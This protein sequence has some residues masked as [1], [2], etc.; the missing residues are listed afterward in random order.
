MRTARTTDR[1]VGMAVSIALHACLLFVPNC[2]QRP[3]TLRVAR[4]VQTPEDAATSVDNRVPAA[5]GD[6]EALERKGQSVPPIGTNA[7]S[8][9]PELAEEGAP[10]AIDRG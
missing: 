6:M 10:S 4:L 7:S 5:S 9:G 8:R 3:A 1:L 2:E